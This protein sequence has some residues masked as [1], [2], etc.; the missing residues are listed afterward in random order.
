MLN[1]LINFEPEFASLAAAGK[2]METD[3]VY[4]L[5]YPFAF[6]TKGEC[7]RKKQIIS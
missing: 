7:K 1:D 2:V 5:Y 6:H 4:T 3:R